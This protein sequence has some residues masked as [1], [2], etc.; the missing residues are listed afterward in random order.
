MYSDGVQIP[1]SQM[2]FI[3]SGVYCSSH[4]CVQGIFIFSCVSYTRLEFGSYK[5]EWWG[6][7]IGWIMAIASMIQV[8]FFFRV[9]DANCTRNPS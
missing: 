7:T 9:S 4:F 6:D 5:Y 1:T 2:F 8:P 3:Y